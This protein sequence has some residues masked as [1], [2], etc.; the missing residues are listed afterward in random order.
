MFDMNEVGAS[1]VAEAIKRMG[2]K[3]VEVS[4]EVVSVGARGL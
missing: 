1:R 3:R 2:G 4:V